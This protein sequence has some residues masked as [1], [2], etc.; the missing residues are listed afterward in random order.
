MSVPVGIT[1]KS[2]LPDSVDERSG[3]LRSGDGGW[4]RRRVNWQDQ[5]RQERL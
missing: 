3:G 1:I 4:P 2:I 5:R